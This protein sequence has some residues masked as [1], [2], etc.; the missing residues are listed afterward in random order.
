MTIKKND[1]SVLEATLESG[2]VVLDVLL[3]GDALADIPFIGTAIKICRAND[4]LRQGIYSAKL[5]KFIN[6]LNSAQQSDIEKLRL[7]I[8]SSGEEARRVGET[9]LMILEQVTDMDKPVVLARLLLCYAEGV[10]SSVEL[11]RLYQA[12]NSAFMD[13]IKEFLA[14]PAMDNRQAAWMENLVS[15]GLSKIAVGKTYDS[16]GEIYFDP[17]PLGDRLRVAH[18]HRP[19]I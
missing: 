10:I 2:E 1:R 16:D 4:T 19:L 3:N 18:C 11:R 5:A 7:T 12:I 8:N 13:D 9:V 6:D 15:A 17:S 14:Q